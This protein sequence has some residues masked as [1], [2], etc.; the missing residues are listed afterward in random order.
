MMLLNRQAN[1]LWT[2]HLC[3]P[4]LRPS[5]RPEL[6]L[7]PSARLTSPV[8]KDCDSKIPGNGDRN[9]ILGNISFAKTL[10]TMRVSLALTL[11]DGFAGRQKRVAKL[12]PTR[13]LQDIYRRAS[14]DLGYLAG[15]AYPKCSGLA[16]TAKVIQ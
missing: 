3:G 13:H 7:A 2:Q 15:D 6:V 4:R 14:V 16:E 10:A 9:I 5:L 12:Q 8:A 11:I 1:H